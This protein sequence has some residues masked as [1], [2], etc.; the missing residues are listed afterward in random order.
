MLRCFA[1]CSYKAILRA[2]GFDPEH[3]QAA[4]D[5]GARG[6][7]T[8]GKKRPITLKELAQDKALPIT[9]LT[10]LGVHD[11]PSSGVG[12]PYPDETGTKREVNRH[13]ALVPREGSYWPAG[14]ALMPYGLEDLIGRLYDSRRRG[15]RSLDGEISPLPLPRVRKIEL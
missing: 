4:Q 13:T 12:I 2:L 6:K 15:G 8:S 5:H 1:G 7:T 10:S 3:F 9:F 14:K 11:H